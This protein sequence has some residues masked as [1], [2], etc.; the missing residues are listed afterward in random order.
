[1]A[2][3]IESLF[4]AHDQAGSFIEA[5][6]NEEATLDLEDLLIMPKIGQQIGPYK[7]ISL[8]IVIRDLKPLR[9]YSR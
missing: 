3:Q 4:A 9:F 2:V 7:I 1:L 5:F 8:I 6:P